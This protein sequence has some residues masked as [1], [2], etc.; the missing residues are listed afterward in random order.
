[1]KLSLSIEKAKKE[2]GYSPKISFEEGIGKTIDWMRE[3]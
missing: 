2:F 1:M 3:L